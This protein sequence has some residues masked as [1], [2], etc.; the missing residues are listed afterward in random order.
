MGVLNSAPRMNYLN[1]F[2]ISTKRR[3][4]GMDG[5]YNTGD[6]GQLELKKAMSK[7]APKHPTISEAEMKMKLK[8]KKS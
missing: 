5:R 2:I 3:E 8:G 4:L 6:E 1:Q 7:S